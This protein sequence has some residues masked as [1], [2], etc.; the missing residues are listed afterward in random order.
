MEM[1]IIWAIVIAAA[2]LLEFFTVDL[3]SVWFSV[4][5]LV[6]LILAIFDVNEYIQVTVFFFLALV[7]LLGLRNLVKKF[8]KTETVH[9]NTDANIGKVTKLISDVVEG[10]SSVKINGVPWT[11]LCDE[12]LKSGASV[13]ITATEGNKFKVK[14]Q[15]E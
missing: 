7:M 8:I 14:K 9:T 3:V 12:E 5:G 1:I 6:A 15:E 11:A 10:R 4:S 2:L 13:V